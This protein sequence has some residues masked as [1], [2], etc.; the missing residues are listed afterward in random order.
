MAVTADRVVVELEARLDRYEANVARA[1]AKF[2]KAMGGIQKSAGATERIVSRAMSGITGA[3]AGVS[4]VAL[5]RSFLTIADEAKKLEAQLRLATAGFGSFGQAQK[6]VQ[7]I[8]DVTRSGLS[9]TASL[10]GNFVRGAK[11]LGATQAEAA[12]AT[13]TFSKTLKISGADAN[14]AA[15]ATLQFGQALAAGALRGDE[16]NS[17]LEASPRLARLLAESMGQPIGQIKKL[18]EEGALTSDKLLRALTNTKFT[19]GID[20]E[21]NQMPVT[22]DDAMTRVYNAALTTFSAFDQ[23]GEFSQMLADF[24]GDGADGFADLSKS[25]EDFGISVRGTLEGLASAFTPFLE[26]GQEAFRLL[27]IDLSNFSADGRKEI[28]GILGA[29]DDLLN[30]GP[31]IANRFGANGRFDSRLAQDFM[32][33]AN[34]SDQRLSGQANERR[35]RSMIGGYDVMGNPLPGTPGASGG[36]RAPPAASTG[37][38]K[39]RTPRSPLDPEA[40]AREEASLNDRILR[41]KND[42]SLTL[43]ER[44]KI[45]LDRVEA[46]RTAANQDVSTDKKYTDAQKAKIVALNDQVAALEAASVIYERDADIAKRTYALETDANKGAQ[47]L[48]QTQ[49]D[50]AE[51]RRQQYEVEKRILALRQS[52][53]RADY[54][55]LLK[56]RNPDDVTRG[57]AGLARLDAQQP[58][59]RAALE[60]RFESPLQAY[61]RRLGRDPGDQV[62]ELITQ[63]LDYVQDSISGAITKRLGVKDPFL[64]GIIDMF[65]QKAII[66]PIAE[67][68]AS[69]GG[70]GGGI[71]GGIV[72][73]IGSIFGGA[74]ANGGPVSAGKSYLVGERG[75]EILR[76]GGSP[77]VVVPN[78]ALKGGIGAGPVVN[79][80]F[81]LDARYGI[82]T[83]ELLQRVENVR[84]E[85]LQNTAAMGSYLNKNM[86]VRMAKFQRDGT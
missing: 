60:R 25:A 20:A 22:F 54:E 41:L 26:A 79:Q 28:A 19:A 14:Q 78:H 29:L 64:S 74:R 44:A 82:T 7:R 50:L 57:R 80:T 62:E 81:V 70:G 85:A 8:A 72:S 56:S 61:S 42:E 58:L 17:I 45:E 10:Y 5:A 49:G 65:I 66:Q 75:P 84:Q 53:E 4:A 67:A 59:E 33:R 30:I 86:P 73:G 1:E 68:L 38:K 69:A 43:E 2:D 32:N 3:L 31:S 13:E 48:L 18:G 6:D 83:P 34:A 76:M 16:L 21:F 24:V 51:T 71:V 37:G 55:L 47:D 15:S 36:R 39:G 77:G 35:F 46:A 12:R 11:E 23:G 52:Q 9:E 40:F 27:G 63:E